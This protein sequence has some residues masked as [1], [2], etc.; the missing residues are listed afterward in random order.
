MTVPIVPG[1]F[2]FLENIGKGVEKYAAGKEYYRRTKREEE[3]QDRQESFKQ[4]GFLFSGIQSGDIDTKVVKSPLFM[5]LIAKSGLGEGFGE[6]VVPSPAAETRK[7]VA[8]A[9]PEAA[10]ALTPT[11]RGIA[12]ATGKLPTPT[13]QA[14]AEGDVAAAGIR[15]KKLTGP[16]TG[17][18]EEIVSGVPGAETASAG[19]QGAQDPTLTNVADRVVRDLYIKL[20]RLPTPAEAHQYG[21]TQDIRAK[22]FGAEL[23]EPYYGSAIERQRAALDAAATARISAQNRGLAG[24]NVLPDIRGQQDQLRQRIANRSSENE[25]LRKTLKFATL[26]GIQESEIPVA[27]LQALQKI[28]ENEQATTVD[29][30]TLT[31]LT[32]QA[33]QVIAP[34]V[35]RSEGEPEASLAKRRLEWD[36]RAK[37]IK[38]HPNDPRVKG[39]TVIQLIGP[40]P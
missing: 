31:G 5:Q 7:V 37:I 13:E 26:P 40:R 34:R 3:F 14:T 2:S 11:G 25:A 8:G 16:L 30:A 21:S 36:R 28:A 12:A 6:N 23:N 35:G 1:P 24:Q 18:Q 4:L 10:A 19:V 39:Q 17:S 20:G 15:T 32:Q 38:D 27:E 33:G 22:P 9:I 29:Q